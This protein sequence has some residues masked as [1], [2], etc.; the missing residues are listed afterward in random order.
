VV[1]W[2]SDDSD[3]DD[4]DDDE[5]SSSDVEKPNQRAI[6]NIALSIK[7]LLFDTTSTCLMAKPTKV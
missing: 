3:D 2:D 1:T 5:K 7:P 4:D 6:A